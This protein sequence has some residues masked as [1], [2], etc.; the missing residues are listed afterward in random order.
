MKHGNPEAA[1]HP[2]P[3]AAGQPVPG[4]APP[5]HAEADIDA[6]AE[7][8]RD[9]S[10]SGEDGPAAGSPP[11][12]PDDWLVALFDPAAAAGVRQQQPEPQPEGGHRTPPFAGR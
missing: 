6:A 2:G 3:E 10:A 11:G 1:G 5:P 4:P 7:A 12:A 8:I 9:E